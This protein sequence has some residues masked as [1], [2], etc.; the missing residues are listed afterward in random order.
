MSND[1]SAIRRQKFDELEQ[2]AYHGK[3]MKKLSISELALCHAF[4]IQHGQMDSYEF[5][6]KAARWFLDES[7]KPRRL[8]NM[9][10][11]LSA[12]NSRAFR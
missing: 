2:D 4:L 11:L 5:E 8:N 3:V 7:N 9:I 12:A 10:E 1:I 6:K